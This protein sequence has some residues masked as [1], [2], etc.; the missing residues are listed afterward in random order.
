MIDTFEAHVSPATMLRSITNPWGAEPDA[1]LLL[2]SCKHE[3][4]APP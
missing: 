3:V 2:S 1:T 4:S